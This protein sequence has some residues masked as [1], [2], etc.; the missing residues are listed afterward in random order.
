M[1]AQIVGIK[2][3]EFNGRDG[4]VKNTKYHCVLEASKLKPE[5]GATVDTMSWNEIENGKPP[6]IKINDK[7]EVQYTKGGKLELI[8]LA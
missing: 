2:R 8:D 7:I 1:I 4:L 6:A 5:E 3:T